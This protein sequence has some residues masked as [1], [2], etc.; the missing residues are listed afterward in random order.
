MEKQIQLFIDYIH[1]KKKT[2]L[3]TEM[4]YKRDL[5]KVVAYLNDRGINSWEDVKYE[6]LKSYIDS[7][8]DGNFANA[9]ISRSV[10]SVKAFFAFLQLIEFL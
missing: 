8:F 1:N 7:M 9:S 3:N 6:D 4:S 2:S 5:L 10:A